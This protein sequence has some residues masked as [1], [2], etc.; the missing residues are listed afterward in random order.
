MRKFTYILIGL[1]M[2]FLT[3]ESHGQCPPINFSVSDTVCPLQPI[4]INNSASTAT[5]FQW[6]F[7]TGDLDSMPTATALPS[8]SGTLSYPLNMKMVEEGGNYYG[9]IVNV[10]NGSY[11][12]RYDFGNSPANTPTAVNLNSDPLLGNST[13]GIDMVKEGNKWYMFIV[14]YGLNALFRYD[15]DSITQLNP[16]LTNLNL[17]GLTAPYSIKILDDYAFIAN[18]GSAEITRIQFGG[19]YTNTPT[20]LA[21]IPTGF[22]NNFGIDVAYDCVS[23]KYI[24]YSTAS[25]SGTLVK[26]DFG[27]SL[28]NTPTASTAATSLWTAQGL[29]LIQEE[30]KWHIFIVTDNNNFYHFTSG[31]SLD[32]TLTLEYTTTFGG[33]MVNPQNI[34]MS[35][36]GSDWI[37]IIPN[38]LLFSIVR[39]QFPQGC[40]GTP[41]SSYA[42]SP[43]GISF[44]PSNLGYNTFELKETLAN[45]STQYF[46]DSVFVE[47][48]PP[49]ARFSYG[50]A[51]LNSPVDFIDSSSICYGALNGWLWDF[52][53]GNTSTASAPSHI[54]TSTGNFQVSLTVY[55]SN[56]DSASTLQ[57]IFVHALPTAWFTR[58]DSACAGSD[59]LFTDSTSSNDGVVQQWNWNFGD[60]NS[61]TGN[62]LTHA[63]INSG[64]F[65]IE[66]I[67]NTEYGCMDTSNRTI[68]ITPGPISNFQVFNTCAGETAQF[69]NLTTATGTS[70]LSTLW[71]FG[72]SNTSSSSSPSHGYGPGAASYSVSLISTAINGCA[73]TLVRTIRIANQPLP[74]FTTN[75]DT[76]CS[77]SDIQFTDSSFAGVGDTISKRVWDFGDGTKDSTSLDPIHVY[78]AAGLYTVTLTVQSPDDCDSS[79]QRSV[80][81]I[82]SP[83][84]NFNVTDVCFGAPSNFMD[85]STAPSGS[86]ITDWSWSFGDTSTSILQSPTHTYSDTGSYNVTLIVKSDIGCYDTLTTLTDVF[87]L[88]VAW[89]THLSACTDKPVQFTDSSQ[90]AGSTIGGWNWSFGANGGTSILQ[91]PTFIYNDPLAFPVTLIVTSVEGCLDTVTRILVA[92]QSP[93]FTISS[94][95]HCFGTNNSFLSIPASG[96]NSTYSYLW[97][98]GDSTASFLPLPL[99]NYATTGNFPVSFLVTDLNNGCSTTLLDTLTVFALPK[100]GFTNSILCAGQTVQFNDTSISTEGIISAWNWTLGS[101]GNSTQQ[102]P[103]TQFS[104]AGTQNIQLTVQTSNGCKDSTLKSITVNALPVVAIYASPNYGAPPLNVQFANTSSAGTYNWQ[105]GDGS[106]GS[107]FAVPTHVFSD[108][109]VY[110]STLVITNAAGCIDSSSVF[111]YVQ[112]PL[113]DLSINGVSYNKVNNKW[114]MKAIVANLGNEDAN[115]FELKANLSGE[116]QFYNT[117]KLD[118]LKAGNI[119][120]YTFPTTLDAGNFTP[121]FFCVDVVSL[122][123]LED[124]NPVNDRFCR[125]TSTSFEIFNVYPNPFEEQ[126]YLGINMIKKGNVYLSLT[127]INGSLQF[128]NKSFELE[129]GLNTVSLSMND[130]AKAVYVLKVRYL[131]TDQYF[132]IVKR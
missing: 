113:R 101:T 9:F 56:G 125:S 105:F 40:M 88:P 111:I 6:D 39:I 32:Q 35:K 119:K 1:F 3:T 120:E 57:N 114:I 44:P 70:I 5:S 22:F 61:G 129:E 84:A 34:Q 50:S 7:C 43:A 93:D 13:T 115:E 124:M 33:I 121:P 16:T 85:V 72:D 15:M 51:C 47:I 30:G 128:E 52:G 17:A 66:L 29:Q 4:L 10:F 90:V 31:N 117:F 45:G 2:I 103:S 77:F 36:V 122:N 58:P 95:N 64:V 18:N 97:N 8:I 49:A 24:G 86:L 130:L 25:G 127:N 65:T 78:S 99:H 71:N 55:S 69:N 112:I 12:T 123:G 89:F 94:P 53:D 132:K 92:N 41:S 28:G 27:N 91:N 59:V 100:A 116:Q 14:S 63:Y 74:W 79:V 23:N 96:S 37:G 54:Y 42:P 68:N 26:I 67:S 83:T 62:T 73:D 19:S 131:E 82:A 108:T 98:F 48:P 104:S 46:L 106:P 38:K 76:A 20:S 11:I 80:F 21:P 81:V 102:N 107:T 60:G 75:L 110:Q 126:L 118:T 109:G 87:S